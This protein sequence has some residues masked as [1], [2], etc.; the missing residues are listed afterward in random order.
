MTRIPPWFAT[1]VADIGAQVRVGELSITQGAQVLA[2][3]IAA[4]PD[5]TLAVA[6]AY[7]AKRLRPWTT[8]PDRGIQLYLFADL[9]GL[10]PVLEVAV[11]RFKRVEVMTG[12]DWDGAMKQIET[13]E[14]NASAQ[15]DRVRAAYARVRPLLTDPETT[16]GMVAG[17]IPVAAL[18]GDERWLATQ[19]GADDV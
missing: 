11:S 17:L 12:A 6:A 8:P 15:A 10:G 3:E 2:G 18:A 14:R 9:P 5:A 16:T 13:K 4:D 7:A 19:E 1:R